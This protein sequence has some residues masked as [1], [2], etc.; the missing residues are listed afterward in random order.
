MGHQACL[1]AGAA[2]E[3]LEELLGLLRAPDRWVL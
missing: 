3:E 1:D 2:L